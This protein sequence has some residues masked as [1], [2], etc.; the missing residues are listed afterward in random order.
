MSRSQPD[1]LRDRCSVAAGVGPF[2]RLAVKSFC[3]NTSACEKGG[4]W[5]QKW[6]FLCARPS[7]KVSIARLCLADNKS[8]DQ[9][10]CSVL[11]WSLQLAVQDQDDST[12]FLSS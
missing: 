8:A 1:C 11:T 7:A 3:A 4:Q 10:T 6:V 12:F 2:S 5:Q 9:R